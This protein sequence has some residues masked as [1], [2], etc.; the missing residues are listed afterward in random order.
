MALKVLPTCVKSDGPIFPDDVIALA[1]R[2]YLFQNDTFC[3]GV[4]I[5]FAALVSLH[6][7]QTNYDCPY[8]YVSRKRVVT[9]CE[10]F[11]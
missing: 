3:D 6:E 8:L 4:D 9:C 2:P 7:V 5:L 11:K 10:A 1:S